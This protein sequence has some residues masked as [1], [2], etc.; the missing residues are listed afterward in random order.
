M[1]IDNTGGSVP[2]YL[3]KVKSDKKALE[4][5]A[6]L[7]ACHPTHAQRLFLVGFLKFCDYPMT[8]VLDIIRG[9]NH[10]CDYSQRI[11][12]YQVASVYH[13][14]PQRTQNHS[15]PRPR[16]WSLSATEVLRIK[17]QRSVSLNKILCEENKG[18]F[19]F[20]HPER[21]VYSAFNPGAE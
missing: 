14:R 10:W 3:N 1:V 16:K 15:A 6:I 2:L 9:H 4:L 8:D 11:T 20:P 18:G 12:A 21:L 17:Y 19:A 5:A 13:Q 7:E